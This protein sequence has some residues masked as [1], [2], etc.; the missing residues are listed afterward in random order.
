MRRSFVVL[1]IAGGLI[2]GSIQ[3]YGHHSFASTYHED[4]VVTVEGKI[5]QFLFRN[6]HSYLHVE[7]PDEH[8]TMQTWA[9]EWAS[10][11]QLNSQGVARETLKPGDVV[12]ITGSPGRDP[13]DHRVRMQQLRRPSDGFEWGKRPEEKVQ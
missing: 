4:R 8:G 13:A 1:M 9:I 2:G 11:G 3:L 7:A 6:P 12:I 10:A 5:V